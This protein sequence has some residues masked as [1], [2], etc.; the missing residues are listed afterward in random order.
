[1]NLW[2]TDITFIPYIVSNYLYLPSCSSKPVAVNGRAFYSKEEKP[3]IFQK[4]SYTKHILISKVFLWTAAWAL[5]CR[6]KIYK[7]TWNIFFKLYKIQVT[8]S[9]RILLGTGYI[10]TCTS[11]MDDYTAISWIFFSMDKQRPVRSLNK[12]F[13][14]TPKVWGSLKCLS[15][16]ACQEKPWLRMVGVGFIHQFVGVFLLLRRSAY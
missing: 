2:V 13:H 9:V 6:K 8:I 11:K 16:S 3:L 15:A 10:H 4:C 12:Y 1:M 5:L 14:I 7:R